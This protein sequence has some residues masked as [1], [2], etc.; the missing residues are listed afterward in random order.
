[1]EA[2][3][4]PHSAVVACPGRRWCKRALTD[5]N[6]IADRI[7]GEL[8]GVLSPKTTVCISGCPNGCAQNAV[9]DIGLSGV[10]TTVDGQRR[11]AF[12]LFAGGGMGRNAELARP[13]AQKLDPDAV[14]AHIASLV[15]SPQP[16]AVRAERIA[17]I[18]V[19][20]EGI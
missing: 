15:S 20:S 10:L 19:A 1:M 13:V 4:V 6:A 12:N 16:V 17:P 11:E 18:C 7:R 2:A 9:A 5:T 8:S 3:A 14:L